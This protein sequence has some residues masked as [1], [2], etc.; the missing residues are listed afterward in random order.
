MIKGK[1]MQTQTKKTQW[2]FNCK[3]YYEDV[4]VGGYCY[5]SKYLNFCERA[6]SEIFFSQGFSPIQ[7]D[8]HFVAKTV[9]AE[10]KSPGLFTDEL[11][12]L[13]SISEY[14][15]ASLTMKHEIFNQNKVLL[16]KMEI[17]LVCLKNSKIAKIPE[18]Y[19]KIFLLHECM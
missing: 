8:Y 4:D 13:T 16:F 6:R 18:I 2:V 1:I 12:V 15:S 5:H 10:Y 3:I 9:N 11:M 19:Q 14:K 7:G 17:V